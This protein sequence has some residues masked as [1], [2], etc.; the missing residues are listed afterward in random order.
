MHYT[1]LYFSDSSEGESK[2]VSND[3][4]EILGN[5][6]ELKVIVDEVENEVI[7]DTQNIIDEK[8]AAATSAKI[9]GKNK[10]KNKKNSKVNLQEPEKSTS[11]I[12]TSAEISSNA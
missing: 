1:F 8:V 4:N 3:E 5:S 9:T 12:V 10:K 7:P 6:I 2:V 11:D